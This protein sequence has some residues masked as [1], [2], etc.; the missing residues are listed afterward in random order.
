MGLD[1]VLWPNLREPADWAEV[2]MQAICEAS[3]D[4]MRM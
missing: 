4:E 1:Q 3:D 2:I